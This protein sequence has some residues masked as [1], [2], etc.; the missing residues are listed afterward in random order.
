MGNKNKKGFTVKLSRIS[1][2]N[3]GGFYMGMENHFLQMREVKK[4]FKNFDKPD[5]ATYTYILYFTHSVTGKVYE[6]SE[7]LITIARANDNVR[8]LRYIQEEYPE[9]LI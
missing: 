7:N 4:F 2:S 6:T 9:Y 1:K 3:S 5:S 8:L